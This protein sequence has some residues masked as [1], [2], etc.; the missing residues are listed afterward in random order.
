MTLFIS[1]RFFTVRAA[2]LI[3]VLRDGKAVEVGDH[4][5]LMDSNHMYAQLYSM[6]EQL[7][8]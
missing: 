1:H 3:V 6:Q 5:R 7:Y 4:A 8:T 2:D